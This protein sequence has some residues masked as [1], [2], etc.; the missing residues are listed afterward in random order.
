MGNLPM[1][2]VWHACL[3]EA[4]HHTTSCVLNHKWLATP[5]ATT[6]LFSLLPTLSH[7]IQAMLLLKD[8]RIPNTTSKL[9]VAS[10]K[11]INTIPQRHIGLTVSCGTTCNLQLLLSPKIFSHPP[12]SITQGSNI[13]CSKL[14]GTSLQFA[15]LPL[16][17]NKALESFSCG[18]KL[19]ARVNFLLQYVIEGS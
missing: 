13:Q 19:H 14:R 8:T 12:W 4:I 11:N 17:V 16:V 5:A 7:N 15:T 18:F 6:L 9:F 10:F 3:H 1:G 2:I